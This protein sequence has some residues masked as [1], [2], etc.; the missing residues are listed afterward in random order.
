MNL[1]IEVKFMKVKSAILVLALG[2]GV[3]A[4]GQT[5]WDLSLVGVSNSTAVGQGI[6]SLDSDYSNTGAPTS[7]AYVTT[8]SG[9][10]RNGQPQ[11]LN[12]SATNNNSAQYGHLQS[13]SH[14]EL[15]NTYYNVANPAYQLPDGSINP[16]GSPDNW[17]SLGFS[18][19][20]DVLHF[21]GS[22]QAGYR[23]R[24]H[25]QY[26]GDN[27]GEGALAD[28]SANVDSFNDTFFATASGP[29]HGIWTTQ[30][31]EI[32]G[33][34]Q[35][36]GAQFSTQ[37]NL[38]A[39]DVP[40]GQTYSITSDFLVTL[41]GIEVLDANDNPVSGWSV[42]SDSGTIYPVPEPCSAIGLGLGAVASL[43]RKRR[44]GS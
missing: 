15:Q 26:D 35:S 43:I 34:S 41:V 38:N 10:D 42:T 32:I 36:I 11:T 44:T 5:L 22:M 6:Y 25:F 33:L 19:F 30:S 20:T 27:A 23:A 2:V 29:N 31:R 24:Y 39:Y 12:Y 9:M 28:L 40:D 8:F 21:G 7:A 37:A 18:A 14:L 17:V 13:F 16:A 3:L 4:H 1:L